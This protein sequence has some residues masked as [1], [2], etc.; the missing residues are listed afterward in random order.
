MMNPFEFFNNAVR[1]KEIAVT[2]ARHGF[3]DLLRQLNLPVDKLGLTHAQSGKPGQDV[4]FHKRIRLV[5][6]E[7]GPTFVKMGQWLAGREELLPA[8]LIQELTQL[9]DQVGAVPFSEMKPL[10]EKELG[11]PLKDVFEKL[12][13]DPVACGSLGQVYH[14]WLL[15]G[16]REVAVK[17]QRPEIR[18]R[19]IA[20]LEILGWFAEQ[21]NEKIEAL[22]PLD[23]PGLVEEMGSGLMAELDFRN[24]ALH[25]ELFN[26]ANPIPNYVYAPEPIK[27]WTSKKLLLTEWIQ[28]KPAHQAD[29]SDQVKKELACRG[30]ES[31]MTQALIQGFFHADPHTGNLALAEDGRIV[32]M[33]WG[34]VGR[35]TREMRECLCELLAGVVRND[36]PH[37]T[38]IA[39]R[40]AT[41]PWEFQSRKLEMELAALLD[42]YRRFDP[43]Q[44]SV[45]RLMLKMIWI[46]GQNGAPP[47]RDFTLLAKCILT[48]EETATKL[49]PNF[50]PRPIAAPFVK[51][52][53]TDR[54]RPSR[55]WDQ[56]SWEWEKWF[57]DFRAL[58]ADGR[59]LIKRLEDGSLPV[60]IRSEQVTPAME[61]FQSSVNRLALSLI[62]VGMIL[63]SAWIIA[64]EPDNSQKI[65]G[66]DS[67]SLGWIG[68]LLSGGL[69][70]W[71]A[72]D[73]LRHRKPK[74]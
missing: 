55:L 58:P 8:S 22:R 3:D 42:K 32:W 47:P 72:W 43:K 13:E 56:W 41:R 74:A 54:W 37:L 53:L 14:G 50:D 73:I 64:S 67:W 38:R 16:S 48:L 19:A 7:L 34:L 68:F 51:K 66:L 26:R 57:R 17:A 9:R 25:A 31:V 6:E 27:N 11:K 35:L 21:A 71:V 5:L 61:I 40:F 49:D 39:T 23:L 70:L 29:V 59:R 10:I 52:V 33:D 69:G 15:E 2:L 1:A 62:L 24:E 46:F 20:D 36:A 12:E 28:G 60:E 18:Q 65:F 44:H 4:S 63:G 45:G 30:A